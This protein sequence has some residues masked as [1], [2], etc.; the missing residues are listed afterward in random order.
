M[1]EMA[2][3]YEDFLRLAAYPEEKEKRAWEAA[4]SER[5]YEA[6]RRASAAEQLEEDAYAESG[7]ASEA[8]RRVWAAEQ[9]EEDISN[10]TTLLRQLGYT[11]TEPETLMTTSPP[12]PTEINGLGVRYYV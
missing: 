11:V 12:D 3:E 6:D 4:E 8:E 2:S 5:A 7:R 1:D 10:A 9:L